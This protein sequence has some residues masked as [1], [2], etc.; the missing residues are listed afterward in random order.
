MN[1]WEKK[2]RKNKMQIG[3]ISNALGI[4]DEKY[5]EIER[6]DR[7]MPDKLV[8][9]FLNIF[10]NKAEKELEMIDINEWYKNTDVKELRKEFGY[11][12]Q[13]ELSKATDIKLSA[14]SELERKKGK[15]SKNNIIKLYH[16]YQDELNR[17]IKPK[18]V[19]K[20]KTSLK[21]IE[22]T[23]QMAGPDICEAIGMHRSN[24]SRWKNLGIGFQELSPQ[25]QSK[26]K[27]LQN[28]KKHDIINIE[29]N[30]ISTRCE[31]EVEIERLKQIIARYEKII[32]KVL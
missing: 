19:E 7:P 16:F 3:V 28:S 20:L 4:T 26:I 14:I 25:V 32:D 12:T 1:I 29:Q 8:N 31:K 15:E 18:K 30:T 2:R 22:E 24:W 11:E 17:K 5:L 13:R 10:N 27:G 9:N 23:L 6:G 21:H